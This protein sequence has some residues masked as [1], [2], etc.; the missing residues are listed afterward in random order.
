MCLGVVETV[1]LHIAVQIEGRDVFVRVSHG[2]SS[3]NNII[4]KFNSFG[5]SVQ[6]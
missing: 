3:L 2:D 1:A 5:E 6:I 4:T